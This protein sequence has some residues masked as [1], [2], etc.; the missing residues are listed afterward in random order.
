MVNVVRS[1]SVVDT[2]LPIFRQDSEPR[3][4]GDAGRPDAFIISTPGGYARFFFASQPREEIN[5]RTLVL[6]TPVPCREEGLN[7]FGPIRRILKSDQG[8]ILRSPHIYRV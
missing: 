5:D 6:T 1:L 3:T 4:T 8:N 7:V 2:T